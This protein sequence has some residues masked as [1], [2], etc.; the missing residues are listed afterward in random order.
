VT[1]IVNRVSKIDSD[2]G[3]FD[4][5]F[6]LILRYQHKPLKD[7]PSGEWWVPDILFLHLV[8]FEEKIDP[9]FYYDD[10]SHQLT[11]TKHY[12]ATFNFDIDLT[13]FPFDCQILSIGIRSFH[14]KLMRKDARLEALKS[15]EWYFGKG[16]LAAEVSDMET[17]EVSSILNLEIPV[18]RRPY[19]YLTHGVLPLFLI[20]TTAW[21][22]FFIN[23]SSFD[24]KL[25]IATLSFLSVVMFRSSISPLLPKITYSN[26]L[27]TYFL[28]CYL[29]LFLVECLNI[30]VDHLVSDEADKTALRIPTIVLSVLSFFA[31]TIFTLGFCVKAVFQ[32]K[33]FRG[34][35]LK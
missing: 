10:D 16:I 29:F 7:V 23:Q 11:L 22:T 35:W 4:V 14:A 34:Q 21:G 17:A 27:S 26:T 31:F 30:S 6:K 8:E 13:H 33:R 15:K 25:V 24:T 20:T 2:R 18:A 9:E 3:T 28:V 12:A 5:D 1:F 32:K 19:F